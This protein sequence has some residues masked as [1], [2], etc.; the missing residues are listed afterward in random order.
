MIGYTFFWLVACDFKKWGALGY[1]LLTL[2]NT[3][4]YLA[5]RNGKVGIGYMSN[6]FLMDDLLSIFLLIYYKR[7]N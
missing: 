6:M 2:V 1:I 3:C 5:I 7:F 4:L